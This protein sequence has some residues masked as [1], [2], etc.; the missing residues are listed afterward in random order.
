MYEVF[1]YP[2][3]RWHRRCKERWSVIF[4]VSAASSRRAERIEASITGIGEEFDD[5]HRAYPRHKIQ[6]DRRRL[7]RTE[8][9]LQEEARASLREQL[10]AL[11]HQRWEALIQSLAEPTGLRLSKRELLNRLCAA[12]LIA[13]QRYLNTL[14]AR[15]PEL[16]SLQGA[17]LEQLERRLQLT[18]KIPS[19]ELNL[20]P[21]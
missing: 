21:H 11:L 17:R 10:R 18:L 8:A 6:R 7:L 15:L 2:V 3:T 1:R 20:Q 5:E 9:E 19:P 16:K 14:I 4:R 13:P 12:A